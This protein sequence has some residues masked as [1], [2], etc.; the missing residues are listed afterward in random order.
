[1]NSDCKYE[2]I[3]NLNDCKKRYNDCQNGNLFLFCDYIHILVDYITKHQNNTLMNY[4]VSNQIYFI[5]SLL[6]SLLIIFFS[7][8]TSAQQAPNQTSNAYCGIE[9]AFESASKIYPDLPEKSR[10]A[11]EQ[12][13]TKAQLLQLKTMMTD[14]IVPVVFHLITPCENNFDFTKVEL[15]DEVNADFTAQNT[16]EYNST[17]D[18]TFYTDQ[19]DIGI[20]FKLAEIDPYGN[21]TD[22]ITRSNSFY[23]IQG[24][25]F[26]IP[27][28]QIIQWNPSRYLN[29]WIVEN[30]N[31]SGYAQ[32]PWTAE[33]YPGNRSLARTA[34]YLGRFY[35]R[36]KLCRPR[37]NLLRLRRFCWRHPQLPRLQQHFL[38]LYPT[39]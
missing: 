22:G 23:S 19:A 38:P 16:D 34:A 39:E 15:E 2:N 7:T 35:D 13:N 28:K 27:L 20:T 3:I 29:V 10:I 11:L 18:P 5:H 37:T 14:D 24:S 9:Q 36:R 25:S 21:P 8:K 26:Q 1:L 17:I 6:F 32:Y 4:S 33:E 12:F 31:T 30:V